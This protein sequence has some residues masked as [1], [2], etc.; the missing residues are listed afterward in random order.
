M[1]IFQLLGLLSKKNMSNKNRIFYWHRKHGQVFDTKSLSFQVKGN[2]FFKITYFNK[3]K[4]AHDNTNMYVY[5]HVSSKFKFDRPK[6]F[7]KA[8]FIYVQDTS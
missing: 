6:G 5:M 1:I 8:L 7:L 2:G 3:I 4:H